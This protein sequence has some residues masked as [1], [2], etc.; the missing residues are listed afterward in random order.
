MDSNE[1]EI[2]LSK[3]STVFYCTAG[4]N[5]QDSLIIEENTVYEI[6]LECIK[7]KNKRRK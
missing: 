4:Y 5:D 7:R 6:D 2:D 1:L 3:Q